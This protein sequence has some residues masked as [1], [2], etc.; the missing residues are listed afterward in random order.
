MAIAVQ[1]LVTT[2]SGLVS[3][4]A[5]EFPSATVA[6]YDTALTFGNSLYFDTT[7]DR[8]ACDPNWMLRQFSVQLGHQ[9]PAMK[10]LGLRMGP[11]KPL[12]G[13]SQMRSLAGG[14]VEAVVK[15]DGHPDFD[16]NEAFVEVDGKQVLPMEIGFAMERK[17]GI[18]PEMSL[19]RV[20]R[21]VFAPDEAKW[22]RPTAAQLLRYRI[23]RQLLMG[24]QW[25][26]RFL[27]LVRSGD[28]EA[29][30]R[31]L[32]R[33]VVGDA[34]CNSYLRKGF[35]GIRG[36]SG[37]VYKVSATGLRVLA[38]LEG[39]GYDEYESICIVFRNGD[40]PPTDAVVM[41]AMMVLHD[42]AELR[43]IGNVGRMNTQRRFALSAMAK[44][45]VSAKAK[46]KDVY[47]ATTLPGIMAVPEPIYTVGNA[48]TF[49]WNA[50]TCAW[51]TV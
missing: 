36:R 44:D 41:K 15:A 47:P 29:R 3:P 45:V 33:D 39:G 26:K 46:K 24:S 34:A 13:L 32:L 1:T 7:N 20:L 30:A 40:F 37:L 48:D 22:L 42:E 25:P 23:Q 21:V 19:S 16:P 4:S 17:P 5:S 14:N 51:R 8:L 2:P 28:P 50:P 9:L 10:D 12:L 31:G 43:M 11:G 27:N 18:G 38:P 6:V 49:V 35:L